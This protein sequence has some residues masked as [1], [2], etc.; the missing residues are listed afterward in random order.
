MAVHKFEASIRPD[1]FF[2]DFSFITSKNSFNEKP[3]KTIY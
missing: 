1:Y 3:P 2:P